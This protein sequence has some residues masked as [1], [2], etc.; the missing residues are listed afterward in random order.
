MA[1]II[2]N[3]DSFLTVWH[4]LF[5][6]NKRQR[7]RIE[8]QR[9]VH[10]TSLSVKIKNNLST[11]KELFLKDLASRL[12]LF[13]FTCVFTFIQILL[14]VKT[15]NS[16]LLNRMINSTRNSHVI[17]QTCR[18]IEQYYMFDDIIFLPFS[19]F[20]LIILKFSSKIGRFNKFITNRFS[21][22]FQ[23]EFYKR[24]QEDRM[25][26]FLEILK[27][28]NNRLLESK[29]GKCKYLSYK[30]CSHYLCSFF[31]CLF[32]C[33]CCVPPGSDTRCFLYYSLR[34]GWE[35]TSCKK[36]FDALIF[37]LKWILLIPFWKCLWNLT[38]R[39][40]SPLKE[41]KDSS[42]KTKNIEL[43]ENES[44]NSED[45]IDENDFN[46]FDQTIHRF[47]APCPFPS[48]P[49]STSN[50]AQS[51]AIYAIYTYDVLNI[52][53]YVYT[54]SLTPK[55]I[56]FLGN[57][58][59][60]GIIL[61]LVIQIIQ[62]IIVGVK[63][64]PI[65]VVA[66]SDPGWFIHLCSTFYMLIIWISWLFRKAFCSR[67]EAFVR[68]AFKVITD[69]FAEQIN[70]TI[71][72]QKN[73]TNQIIAFFTD[74]EN[75]SEKYTNAIKSKIPKLFD[76]YFGKQ[77][78]NSSNLPIDSVNF[79]ESSLKYYSKNN[80]TSTT[81]SLLDSIKSSRNVS[82]RNQTVSKLHQ[83]GEGAF[84]NKLSKYFNLVEFFEILPLYFLLSYL[85]TSHFV[86][87]L[88]LFYKSI[89][90]LFNS[91]ESLHF[92]T[93]DDI[94]K[95]AFK[96]LKYPGGKLKTQNHNILYINN[97][98]RNTVTFENL[99]IRY[100]DK[101]YPSKIVQRFEIS[102]IWGIIESKIY[103]NIHYF[104]YSKQF[105]NTY[106]V[107]FMV[108]YFFCL[109]GLQLSKVLGQ[110]F[111]ESIEN[112]YILYLKSFSPFLNVRDHNLTTEINICIMLASSFMLIQLLLSIRNYRKDVLRLHKGGK[113]FRS[114]V[115][116]YK[117]EDNKTFI[118]KRNHTSADITADSL[119]F[120]GFL[121]AHLVYGYI[122]LV[123]IFLGVMITVKI[124]FYLSK[125]FQ[126]LLQIFFP[127]IILFVLKSTFLRFLVRWV[128]LKSDRQRIVN[129][130][131]YFLISYF[132]F[133]F[134]CFLGLFACISRVWK[135]T[136]I[137]IIYLP[138]LDKSMFDK[139]NEFLIRNIDKGHLAYINQ[140]R[141]EHWYNNNIL[142]G[143]CE[144]LIESMFFSQFYRDNLKKKSIEMFSLK[145][146]TKF[147]IN[148]FN[149]QSYL[150]L[151]NL[152]FLY[153][154]L[155]KNSFLI[156]YRYAFLHNLR[157]E[158]QKNPKFSKTESAKEFLNSRLN[159]IIC[160][161][162][163]KR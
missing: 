57:I 42:N 125:T 95:I 38:K 96:K 114:L 73:F 39:N 56:P 154:L 52:F 69:Q 7:V 109:F 20:F 162:G 120:P 150:R 112:L 146:K 143:F 159:K 48:T 13:L 116:K 67:S 90:N 23:T 94:N 104:R 27:N 75:A 92:Q 77:I 37:I 151:R 117:D 10:W 41:G 21:S 97:F 19:L 65:L 111:V 11:I 155:K 84:N 119:H 40:N 58:G 149:Y 160:K 135:T 142:N 16:T 147:D 163:L 43:D 113:F 89:F 148:K 3:N 33:S 141:M 139:E 15:S 98:F 53:M 93:S 25:Q 118:R 126:M 132:N 79:Y 103:K 61:D 136:L 129:I 29:C 101:K 12:V 64:Y 71:D 86:K 63:F 55:M 46:A 36:I 44:I 137:S 74:E 30:C 144:I 145:K 2:C 49:F 108:I 87:F 100:E 140:V 157:F 123:C 18:T 99:R 1:I 121:I 70:L 8:S 128:L 122:I 72:L 50:R 34:L 31:C 60:P 62:V 28:K 54:L 66:D 80:Y 107:A 127:I 78:N 6:K 26:V 131:P 81:S 85:V 102:F 124:L 9:S 161:L 47:K 82:I 59:T 133:F 51:A 68:Q 5:G 91:K 153:L 17:K 152:I 32:C 83:F 115:L 88:S 24:I 105:V 14:T 106:T 158:S 130:A 4:Y 110:K 76:E 45:V 134:D 35:Q 138:R 22:Y 156:K